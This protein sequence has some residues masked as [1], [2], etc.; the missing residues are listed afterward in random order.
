MRNN[1]LKI[2]NP[3]HVLSGKISQF[4]PK[5]DVSSEDSISVS[6]LSDF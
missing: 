2:E 6:N 5:D 1:S 3:G 4:K